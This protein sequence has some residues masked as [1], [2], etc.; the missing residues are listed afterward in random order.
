MSKGK[1]DFAILVAFCKRCNQRR[2]GVLVHSAQAEKDP[3][4][5]A[6]IHRF[7]GAHHALAHRRAP[8]AEYT[9]LRFVEADADFFDKTKGAPP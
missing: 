3:E 6:A 1:P 9:V 4:A 5:R 7:V 8:V 2:G